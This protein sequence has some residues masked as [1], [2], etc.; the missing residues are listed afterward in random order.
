MA[1]LDDA[2]GIDKI[3]RNRPPSDEASL[4]GV[5]QEGDENAESEG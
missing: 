5:D 1:S 2:G 4:V 3:F